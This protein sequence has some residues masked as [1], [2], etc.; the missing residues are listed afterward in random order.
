MSVYS[1]YRKSTAVL[2]V[3]SLALDGV[4]QDV[5]PDTITFIM[6]VN[7]TDPDAEAIMSGTLN[8]A[9]YG[10][11]SKAYKVFSL[12]DTDIKAKRYHL[13]VKWVTPTGST[14]YPFVGYTVCKQMDFE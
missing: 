2:I 12:T 13:T 11:E 3:K 8:V 14:Y 5:T 10:T 4:L 9:D 6:K 7:Q 1:F